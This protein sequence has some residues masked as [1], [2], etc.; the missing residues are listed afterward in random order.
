MKFKDS[1]YQGS[2]KLHY[3]DNLNS[4][5][6]FLII[7]PPGAQDA[8][9]VYELNLPN[10]LSKRIISISYPS[11]YRSDNLYEKTNLVSIV[12]ILIEFLEFISTAHK[13]SSITIL[14]CSFGTMIA[15]KIIQKQYYDNNKMI[16]R[17]IFINPGEFFPKLINRILYY[18]FLPANYI[19]LYAKFL[20]LLVTDL[21]RVH[22]KTKFS[23]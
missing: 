20:R 8:R 23:R 6:E 14:G 2:I 3:L 4:S 19:S 17:L 21:L 15:T 13:P 5:K 9:F 1:Y 11:R 10:T 16:K 12:N 7:F 18:S 22:K